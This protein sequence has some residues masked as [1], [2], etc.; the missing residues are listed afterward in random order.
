MGI[1]CTIDALGLLHLARIRR[2]PPATL[3]APTY[4]RSR[5]NNDALPL[6]AWNLQGVIHS[7]LAVSVLCRGL[8][9]PDTLGGG[10]AADDSVLGLFLDLLYQ[11]SGCDCRHGG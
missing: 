4:R 11:V 5:N 9:G 3:H 8:C 10:D 2:H 1:C 7:E 6:R